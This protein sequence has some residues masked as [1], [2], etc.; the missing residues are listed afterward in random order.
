[1]DNHGLG[2][3]GQCPQFSTLLTNAL[4]EKLDNLR[5]AVALQF[6]HYNYARR[7]SAHDLPP[8]VTTGTA[9]RRWRIDNLLSD[10]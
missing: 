6:T 4:S 7:R 9:D 5:A 3:G 1:M 2:G 10:W 8:T